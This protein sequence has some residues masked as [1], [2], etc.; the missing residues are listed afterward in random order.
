MRWRPHEMQPSIDEKIQK[1][2]FPGERLLWSGRPLPRRVDFCTTRY[3]LTDGRVV[4]WHGLFGRNVRTLALGDMVG[5]NVLL[6]EQRNR[7]GTIRFADFKFAC[8]EDRD[9][10]CMP[11]LERIPDARQVV[12]LIRGA[13]D[14]LS[15]NRVSETRAPQHVR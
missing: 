5:T 14:R 4:I 11:G 3:A 13:I 6:E 15:P 1:E 2:L 12:S 9:I 7:S 10:E 8:G